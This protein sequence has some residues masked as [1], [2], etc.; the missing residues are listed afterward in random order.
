MPRT[1]RLD[2][3]LAGGTGLL[4]RRIRLADG[5]VLSVQA[6]PGAWCRPRP[7]LYGTGN[8]P[9]DYAGPY[10]HIEVFLVTQVPVPETWAPY[11]DGEQR[12]FG[13][14]PADLVRAFVDEHG[15]E[16]EEQDLQDDAVK[17]LAEAFHPARS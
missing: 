13:A 8:A 3:V 14:V 9:A 16:H 4:P 15:G 17:A 6:G 5:T 7:A 10:T 1:E 2:R 12:H 11:D